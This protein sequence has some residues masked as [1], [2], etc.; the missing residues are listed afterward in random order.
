MCLSEQEMEDGSDQSFYNLQHNLHL[1]NN[2]I[3]Y[4]ESHPSTPASS[5]GLGYPSGQHGRQ[6]HLSVDSFLPLSHQLMSHSMTPSDDATWPSSP[7]TNDFQQL[8][9]ASPDVYSELEEARKQNLVL[10]VQLNTMT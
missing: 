8:W 6:P 1:P 5:T 10:Q 9:R 4:Y 7:V 2:S 3:D